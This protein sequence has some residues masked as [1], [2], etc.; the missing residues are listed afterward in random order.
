[1]LNVVGKISFTIVLCELLAEAGLAVVSELFVPVILL[2]TGMLTITEAI[3]KRAAKTA[4]L[5]MRSSQ[6]MLDAIGR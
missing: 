2:L 6:A 3:A 5:V 1:M 4:R